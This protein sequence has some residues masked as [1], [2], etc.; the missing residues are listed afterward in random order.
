[1][2]KKKASTRRNGTALR[3]A[4]LPSASAIKTH[5]DTIVVGQERSKRTL[6]VA[7]VNHLARINGAGQRI[8]AP[9]LAGVTIEKSNVLMIGPTGSGKTYLARA[10]A[11]KLNVPFSISDATSLTEAGYVGQDVENIL[12]DL[13]QAAD[14][15]I[16][17]AQRGIV[18]IDEFC[19]IRKTAENISTTR[20]VGGEGVQQSIL[21]MI[22]GC[23]ENTL[24]GGGR[25]HPEVP[26]NSI[27]TTNILFICGGAFVGLENIIAERLPKRKKS[28]L[29]S[30]VMP[31]DLIKF[32]IIPELVGRLPVMTALRELTIDDMQA[33]LTTPKNALL[34]QYRKQCLCQDFDVEFS[35]C[36]VKAIASAAMKMQVGARGLR[37]V[38]ENVMLDI[39]FGAKRGHQYLINKDVVNG[40]KRPKERPL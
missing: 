25:V 28:D 24:V 32:G 15:D 9:E 29:M 12:G 40:T 19:K 21:K 39:Q 26:T 7:V 5:L 2:A 30:H 17:A 3:K 38:V 18:F 34:K 13:I 22:E 6:A 31:H 27:D 37:S 14:D 11:E 4:R 35:D 16:D 8:A 10:L 23:S 20:D 1:M 36:A 33:I